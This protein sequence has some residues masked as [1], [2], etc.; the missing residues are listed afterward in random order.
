MNTTG[1]DDQLFRAIDSGA[2]RTLGSAARNFTNL[3]TNAVVRMTIALPAN[4]KLLDCG[5]AALCPASARATAE[6]SRRRGRC[7]A[8]HAVDPG[9]QDHRPWRA[10]AGLVARAQPERRLP[11]RCPLRYAAEPGAQRQP[12]QRQRAAV[13]GATRHPYQR[14]AP[15]RHPDHLPQADVHRHAATLQLHALHAQP[16]EKPAHLPNH[17]QPRAARRPGRLPALRHSQPARHCQH[18]ACC[19]LS[20]V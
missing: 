12:H 19:P 14:G 6:R 5:A 20:P 4:I 7:V 10:C 15:P 1:I 9:C 16:D 8:R 2:F 13:A 18:G 3:I 11:D 17:Q